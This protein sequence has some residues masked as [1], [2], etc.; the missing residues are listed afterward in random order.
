MIITRAYAGRSYTLSNGKFNN[1]RFPTQLN[2][3]TLNPHYRFY[4]PQFINE[5]LMSYALTGGTDGTDYRVF[6]IPPE[7]S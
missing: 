2:R 1:Y 3:V 4:Y 7:A 5:Y 6:I